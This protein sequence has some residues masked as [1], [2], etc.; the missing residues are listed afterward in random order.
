[1]IST[2]GSGALADLRRTCAGLRARRSR[3]TADQSP[4]SLGGVARQGWRDVRVQVR[5][6]RHDR[7]GATSCASGYAL[8][9]WTIEW[10]RPEKDD[11]SRYFEVMEVTPPLSWK[12][13]MVDGSF[14]EKENDNIADGRH[15]IISRSAQ[16]AAI[17]ATSAIDQCP[18]KH[19]C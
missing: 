11:W 4:D 5:R 8:G 15:R 17:S 12:E 6:D 9:G 3:G 7:A 13:G 19:A 18:R 1:M 2:S 10:P 14:L 16:I